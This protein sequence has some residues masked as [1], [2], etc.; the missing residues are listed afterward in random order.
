MKYMVNLNGNK[1]RTAQLIDDMRRVAGKLKTSVLTMRL[2]ETYGKYSSTC[3]YNRFGSWISAVETAGLKSPS[4][5]MPTYKELLENIKKVWRKLK[6]QPTFDM[7]RAPHSKF[8][9]YM[10]INAFGT[11]NKTLKYFDLYLRDKKK[12]RAA[13]LGLADRKAFKRGISAAMRLEIFKRDGYRCNSC[14]CSPVNN[15]GLK[16]TIDH[17]KPISRGGRT[18]SSNLQTLCL[19]CNLKKGGSR[20]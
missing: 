10:Y 15:A 4:L 18:V 19:E 3:C 20:R 16:L 7:V 11:W 1:V 2:Y 13:V 5:I 17:V 8:P 14:R 12:Y 6:R 9:G